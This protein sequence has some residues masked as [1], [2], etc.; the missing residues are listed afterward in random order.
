ME[1]S[2]SRSAS[3]LCQR[4][5]KLRQRKCDYCRCNRESILF[6]LC[7]TKLSICGCTAAILMTGNL[8]PETQK[9]S[10]NF[11]RTVIRNTKYAAFAAARSF[12][13][14][15]IDRF[16]EADPMPSLDPF[17]D[18]RGE[19]KPKHKRKHVRIVELCDELM[20]EPK[21][22]APK[23]QRGL[24]QQGFQV[25]LSTIYRIAKDLFFGWTKPWHTDILTPAQKLKRK[26]FCFQLLRLT[27]EALLRVISRWM[28]TDE[29]WWDLV[30]PA[31]AQWKKG[32]T[33][34]ERKMQNQVQYFPG[35][36]VSH[37]V[38]VFNIHYTHIDTGS[39]QQEQERRHQKASI[40]LGRHLLVW[41]DSGQRLD[42][43]RHQGNLSSHKK[44]V[45]RHLV[46]G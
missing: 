2:W 19:N 27:D 5:R 33:K 4:Q 32:A 17:R 43:G 7:D 36:I 28:F 9:K 18:L 29:K 21:S 22:T 42:G 23:V 45:C 6:F 20:S 30:G 44:F 46:P 41:K 37:F 13:Y 15:A 40:F 11:C 3:A 16:R 38:I 12:V 31:A 1:F 25:S 10:L 8:P 34:M 24:R 39:A 35:I 14:R 26:L